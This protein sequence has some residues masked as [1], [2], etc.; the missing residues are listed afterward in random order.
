[1]LNKNKNRR[2]ALMLLE[3]AVVALLG[4]TVLTSN[5]IASKKAQA[6]DPK[7][8]PRKAKKLQKSL[9]PRIPS[10]PQEGPPP[11]APSE[12]P[13]PLLALLG[14]GNL[15]QGF[16]FESGAQGATVQAVFGT[17]EGVLWHLADSVCRA[18]LAG[19][20]TPHTFY[21]GKD[22]TCTYDTGARTASNLITAPFSLAG[23][24]GPYS[25]GFNYLLFVEGG[26][27]DTT[28]VD[29][30]TNNGA[31]WTQ[32][33]SK[34]NL[35]NDN[36]WHNK[37]ADVTALVGAA[38]SIRLRFRFDSIDNIANSTT[39]WHVDDIIVCGE[40]DTC[41]Q[42]DSARSVLKINSA[43][44]AYEF[45]SCQG[46]IVGGVGSLI[47]RGSTITLQDNRS[48]RR[49]LAKIDKSVMKA[50]ASIQT[51][52]PSRL[53]TLADRNTADNTCVCP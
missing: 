18:V 35:I 43:T 6:D 13:P 26:G 12:K 45:N 28:F 34:A 33:L 38:T 8:H 42:D 32:I 39:G 25:I 11:E 46:T 5:S 15:C 31:T 53:F 41:I 4:W 7:D 52:S 23:Q 14:T 10:L 48:D 22:A 2:M 51:F 24:I 47:V 20:S 21:Y 27:F 30:S 1:M 3:V 50:A 36:Q 29:L 16:D 17:P 40:F 44:G 49:V 37:A 19:H 9:G